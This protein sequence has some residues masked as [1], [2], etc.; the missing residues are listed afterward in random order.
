MTDLGGADLKK[1]RSINT[2]APKD[3]RKQR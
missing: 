3:W 2:Y 1:T